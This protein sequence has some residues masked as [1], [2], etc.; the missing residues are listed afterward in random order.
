MLKKHAKEMNFVDFKNALSSEMLNE[1]TEMNISY[2]KAYG[3]FVNMMLESQHED[4]DDIGNMESIVRN[5]ILDFK[6]ELIDL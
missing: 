4:E 2:Q 5:I 1:L 6:D 3:L